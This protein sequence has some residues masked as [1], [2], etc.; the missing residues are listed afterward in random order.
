MFAKTIFRDACS[1]LATAE[2]DVMR[3]DEGLTYT[4]QRFAMRTIRIWE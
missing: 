3:E 2:T 1:W 4:H